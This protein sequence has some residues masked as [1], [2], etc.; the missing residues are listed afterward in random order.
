MDDMAFV[1]GLV[2][3]VNKTGGDPA[4]DAG[5]NSGQ[6]KSQTPPPA[7]PK[8]K[9]EAPENFG[10]DE[11]EGED[12]ENFDPSQ[13]DPERKKLWPK[14][15]ANAL[16]R[17]DKENTRIKAENQAWAQRYAE[18]ER[19]AQ[20]NSGGEQQPGQGQQQQ[21]QAKSAALQKLEGEK[22]DLKKYDDFAKFQEDLMDWKI[23]VRDQQAS[24]A[25]EARAATERQTTEQ[26]A[27][28][29][30][31]ENRISQQAQE[32]IKKNPEVFEIM[33][34]NAD[35]ID[36]LPQPI[37]DVIGSLQH[38]VLAMLEVV[39][40]PGALQALAHVTQAQAVQILRA[41]EAQALA[42]ANGQASGG[43][44]DDGDGEPEGGQ[45][46]QQ[47][48]KKVSGAPMPMGAAK[49]SPGGKRALH[50]MNADEILKELDIS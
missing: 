33:Q 28:I 17:R 21:G 18:L 6:G 47:Q 14:K 4:A 26:K 49:A 25:A 10:D 42:A 32:I 41:A 50:Q 9:K 5:Q 43:E 36:S 2:A 23:K 13:V 7:D 24:E 19:K 11:Y 15:Y 34:A 35:L 44:A 30:Q 46:Q 3:E 27:A 8:A 37:V 45:G 38:P 22:P 1:D 40:H 29:A 20:Q 16:S 31:N 48:P 12:D 39:K